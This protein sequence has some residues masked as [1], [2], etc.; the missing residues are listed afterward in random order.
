MP[1]RDLQRRIDLRPMTGGRGLL[2]NVSSHGGDFD[3]DPLVRRDGSHSLYGAA[4]WLWETGAEVAATLRSW[5]DGLLQII[6]SLY[7][8]RSEG[9]A[10]G[11]YSMTVDG[12]TESA[13]FQAKD[14]G[15]VPFVSFGALDDGDVE[16]IWGNIGYEG[17]PR[18]YF[19][20]KDDYER[21]VPLVMT[22]LLDGQVDLSNFD[23]DELAGN[24][25][26][27][28]VTSLSGLYF[29]EGQQ[30]L[31]RLG[32]DSGAVYVWTRWGPEPVGGYHRAGPH[33]HASFDEGEQLLLAT[34]FFDVH[35][36]TPVQADALVYDGTGE[37]WYNGD[38]TAARVALADAGAYFATD[39]VEA[40]MRYI[41]DWLFNIEG[42][43]A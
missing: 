20:F 17:Y 8:G 34:G 28:V 38:V 43:I 33:N 19:G 27:P 32:A 42:R 30:F 6:G 1:K 40:G 26:L 21:Q 12:D 11:L 10:V 24:L 29:Q 4:Q 37:Y 25:P 23:L 13:V 7:V 18:I 31:L 2:S 36:T 16:H 3:D 22:E 39:T 41:I 35:I 9:P 15:N 5:G 14:T